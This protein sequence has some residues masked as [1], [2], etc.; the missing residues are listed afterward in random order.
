MIILTKDIYVIDVII[1][2]LCAVICK[3]ESWEEIEDY[4]EMKKK[5]FKKFLE[6]PNGIPS[7]DTFRRIFALICP[8]EFNSA[9]INWTDTIRK[10]V[11]KEIIAIDGKTICGS[12][13]EVKD[14]DPIHMVSA[15][16]AIETNNLLRH[17][18]HR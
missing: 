11:K 8:K 15:W 17:P 2:S 3:C 4:G 14:I 16:S 5:W 13:S 18:Y 7:H 1:I 9:F 6:L 10:K 12:G